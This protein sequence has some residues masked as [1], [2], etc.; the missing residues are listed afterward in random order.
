VVSNEYIEIT[1]DLIK[2]PPKSERGFEINYRPLIVSEQEVD[3][4]LKNPA[5]GDFKYKLLL[6]GLVP[7]T[8][9]SMAFKCAL[10]ADLVQAFKFTHYLK[11][12][13]NYS[14]K[15][16][17]LDTP[18]VASDFKAE[19]AQVQA[20]AADS[21]KGNEVSVNVRYEP[22]TIGDSRAILK[23]NSPEGMEYTCLLFGKSTAPVPQ[24]S[25][26]NNLIL[27]RDLSSVC[28]VLNQVQLT[29]RIHLMRRAS[30]RL[31]SI[32]LTSRWHL[33]HLDLL[34]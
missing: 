23:L 7:N 3:L 1:P 11:K 30:S 18:G 24:V 8:Q 22:Y 33:S 5:L 20:P 21:A 17:R 13:S 31:L 25:I 15:I 28:L 10:G 9:R 34:M 2:V 16:E 14:V 19:V 26:T 32:T 4:V 29:L 6:K 27:Y 12:P